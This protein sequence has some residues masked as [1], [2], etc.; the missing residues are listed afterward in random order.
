MR[1]T[2]GGISRVRPETT[3]GRYSV[4]QLGQ[5]NVFCIICKKKRFWR[6]D[7]FKRNPSANSEFTL[8]SQKAVTAYFLSMQLLLFVLVL[9]QPMLA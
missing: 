5:Y 8:Q 6:L 7:T 4:K 1:P 2:A 9:Q 3:E